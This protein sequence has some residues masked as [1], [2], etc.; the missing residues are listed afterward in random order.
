MDLRLRV[1]LSALA[2]VTVANTARAE[3]N[4][5]RPRMELGIAGGAFLPSHDHEIFNP[6]L[7]SPPGF[8]KAGLDVSLRLGFY[9]FE[10]FGGELEGAVVPLR[11]I[12]D[13][14][15]TLFAMRG[16][17]IVQ[18]PYRF[19]PF[20]LA[21]GGFWGMKS[22]V[23][24]VGNDIDPTFHWGLGLKYS[25]ARDI[26]FRIDARHIVSAARGHGNTDHFEVLTGISFSFG[27]DGIPA[28]D[29]RPIIRPVSLVQAA[30]PVVEEIKQ[31]EPMP[32]PVAE[33]AIARQ[34]EVQQT[35]EKIEAAF[36]RVH[37]AWGSFALRD[38]DRAALDD[39]VALL[40]KYESLRVEIRGHTDSTGPNR[41]NERLSK[42]RALAVV[43]Y[44]VSR[45]VDE[46]RLD[47]HGFGPYQPIDS[48][49]TAKGR[50]SNRRGEIVVE[51]SED[52]NVD[53]KVSV[54]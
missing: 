41:F 48:N 1:V 9:P 3:L 10:F 42:K 29:P 4:L 44:L 35:R 27:D 33:E 11:T 30:P 14:G 47:A 40:S 20:L 5:F 49:V 17:G 36:E 19:T 23:N 46:K 28:H 16:H 6:K 50:A 21:G 34:I 7:S 45:G 13:N 12:S 18:L 51:D 15:G 39:A 54:R 8:K 22:A 43:A 52:P 32:A 24:A 2:S 37:F 26:S 53:V 31:P 25:Y 38:S